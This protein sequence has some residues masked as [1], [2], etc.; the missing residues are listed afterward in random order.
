MRS[1]RRMFEYSGRTKRKDRATAATWAT[2]VVP[3]CDWHPTRCDVCVRAC[4][5]GL[6]VHELC[7]RVSLRVCVSVLHDFVSFV[8][9]VCFHDLRVFVSFCVHARVLVCCVS[10]VCKSNVCPCVC[11]RASV[12]FR[13][14]RLCVNIF[15]K[16]VS[17]AAPTICTRVCV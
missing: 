15:F 11:V 2:P 16:S 7:V 14:V 8:P 10:S 12:L 13:N 17:I 6:Y 1:T 5:E 9:L 4:A 3:G